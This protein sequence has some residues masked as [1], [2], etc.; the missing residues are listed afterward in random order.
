MKGVLSDWRKVFVISGSYGMG[1]P[2]GPVLSNGQAELFS[3]VGKG[4][5]C[6]YESDS[7]E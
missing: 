4:C 7:I 6:T 2:P 1:D 5:F 3:S